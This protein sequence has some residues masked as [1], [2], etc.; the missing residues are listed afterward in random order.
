MQRC[1]GPGPPRPASAPEPQGPGPRCRRVAE[2]LTAAE[3]WGHRTPPARGSG[4][5]VGAQPWRRHQAGSPTPTPG[6]GQSEAPRSSRNSERSR[7]RSGRQRPSHLPSMGRGTDRRP[8]P[9][10]GTVGEVGFQ[11]VPHP[12]P[13]A[14]RG[15][16]ESGSRVGGQESGIGL[17]ASSI[18]TLEGNARSQRPRDLTT[19]PALRWLSGDLCTD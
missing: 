14:T 8:A 7:G 19:A 6:S 18:H 1:C 10:P 13:R 2:G 3:K 11:R 4:A 12:V 15:T 9:H 16:Q 5:G 17:R